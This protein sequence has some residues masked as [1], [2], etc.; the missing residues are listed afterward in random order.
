MDIL[1][2]LKITIALATAG[3]RLPGSFKSDATC[4]LSVGYLSILQMLL[5]EIEPG[6]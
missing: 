6:A 2:V 3:T 1:M 4:G 5:M